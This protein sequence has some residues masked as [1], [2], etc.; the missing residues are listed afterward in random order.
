MASEISIWSQYSAMI[1]VLREG[2]RSASWKPENDGETLDHLEYLYDQL[3]EEE[4]EMAE[5][6]WW[7]GWPDEYDKRQPK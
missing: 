1:D 6:E 2:R 7:R 5:S 4:M 3:T